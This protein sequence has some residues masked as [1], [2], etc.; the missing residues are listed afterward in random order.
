MM[1]VQAKRVAM[2]S[3]TDKCFQEVRYIVLN[4]TGNL[5]K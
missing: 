3:N 2:G 4:E 5:S 1:F